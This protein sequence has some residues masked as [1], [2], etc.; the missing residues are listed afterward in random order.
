MD[1]VTSYTDLL[2]FENG[3]IAVCRYRFLTCHPE[4]SQ[5]IVQIDNHK[6]RKGVLTED[7]HTRDAILNRL[8]DRELTGIPFEMLCVVLSEGG[9][10]HVVF[11]EPDLE[12]YIHRG[13]PH[14]QTPERAARGRHIERISIDSRHLVVGKAR[15]HTAHATP[16]PPDEDLALILSNQSGE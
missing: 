8:A 6:G 14:Q 9:V 10:H 7:H 15:I 5:V 3:G 2:Y 16:T 12:D 11:P 1:N 13:Y 4:S